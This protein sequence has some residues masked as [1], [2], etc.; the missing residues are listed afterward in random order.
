MDTI[1]TV[2]IFMTAGVARV[3]RVKGTEKQK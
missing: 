1:S 2:E 3:I